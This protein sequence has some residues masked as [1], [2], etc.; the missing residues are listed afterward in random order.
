MASDL[1]VGVGSIA[2][3]LKTA[4]KN[5][6]DDDEVERNEIIARA[7]RKVEAAKRAEQQIELDTIAEAEATERTR[8]E[9]KKVR[10]VSVPK[11]PVASIVLEVEPTGMTF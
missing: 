3:I 10:K 8:L 6:Y 9:A 1:N 11:S 5:V 7:A 4:F 2:H